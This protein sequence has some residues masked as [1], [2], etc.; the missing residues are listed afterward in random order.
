MR[1]KR[2]PSIVV[3]A[4][5]SARTLIEVKLPQPEETGK[6]MEVTLDGI[7]ND[8]SLVQPAKQPCRIAATLGGIV[9][10]VKLVSASKAAIPIS[11]IVEGNSM[12]DKLIFS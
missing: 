10:E 12:I 2:T 11:I 8:F 6:K 5:L 9:N 1:L 4:A 7:V 3:N